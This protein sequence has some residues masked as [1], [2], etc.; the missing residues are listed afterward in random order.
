MLIKIAAVLLM[1][2]FVQGEKL[3]YKPKMIKIIPG[4]EVE[5][6]KKP[7][8]CNKLDCPEYKVIESSSGYEL[9]EYTATH[10]VST[11]LAGVDYSEAS[12]IM[13]HRL[14]DYIQGKNAKKEKIAMT[15]PVLVR[16]IPGPGPACESNFTMSFFMSNKVTDPPAPTDPT[17]ALNSAP[18]FRAY[19]RQFGGY[20]RKIEDW[21]KEAQE[22]FKS[23]NDSSKY[24]TQ[25]YFTAGYD[26]P[27]RIFKRHNE[28]WFISK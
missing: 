16:L 19:V 10:W 21:I 15:A 18:T 25:F 27:F 20:V 12:G 1:A 23:I 24:H 2:V 9:R 14:F 22:L 5:P 6:Q 17:V 26:S 11:T 3:Y 7:D 13:F 28:I 8:F 4:N